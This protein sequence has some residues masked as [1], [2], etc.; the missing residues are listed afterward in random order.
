MPADGSKKNYAAQRTE[1]FLKYV[2]SK[3]SFIKQLKIRPIHGCTEFTSV[4]K[5]FV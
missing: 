2:N 5:M 1:A 3:I 4:S